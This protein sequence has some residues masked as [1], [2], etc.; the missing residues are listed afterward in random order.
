M[1]KSETSC[2]Y[3]SVF[4]CKHVDFN[5][6]SILNASAL[7]AIAMMSQGLIAKAVKY[8]HRY[9]M[10]SHICLILWHV[11]YE[12]YLKSSLGWT[13]YLIL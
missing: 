12:G 7:K 6:R 8:W 4:V 11:S 9:H 5:I 10:R 13:V 2:H 3:K 1:V